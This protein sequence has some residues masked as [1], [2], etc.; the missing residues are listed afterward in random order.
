[1]S[2]RSEIAW[3][4]KLEGDKVEVCARRFGDRW[5][6]FSRGGRGERWQPITRP[7]LE[8]WLELLDGVRRRIGRQRDRPEEESRLVALIREQ[9]PAANVV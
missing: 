2:N 5:S 7:G 6:F 8:D 9:F 4:R 1:M 3:T